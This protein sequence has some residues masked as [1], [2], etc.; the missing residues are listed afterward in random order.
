MDDRSSSKRQMKLCV[1]LPQFNRFVRLKCGG[2]DNVLGRMAR[3]TQHGIR[4]PTQTLYNFFAL[5]IPYVD[6]IVFAARHN[7]LH[8]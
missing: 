3:R 5:K 2:R 1:A 6:H 8:A 4:V 7:P